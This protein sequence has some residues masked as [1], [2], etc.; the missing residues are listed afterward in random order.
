VTLSGSTDSGT[1]VEL[2]DDQNSRGAAT[3]SGGTWSKTLTL[4]DGAHHFTARA[5]D[6]A[7]NQSAVSD[8]RTFVV[9]TGAPDAPALSGPSGPINTAAPQFTFSTSEQGASFECALDSADFAACT[10]PLALSGI[11]EGAH[12]FK[13]RAIDAAHNTGPVASTDFTVDLTPPAEPTVVSG[14]SGPTTDASPAFD[15]NE[16]EQDVTVE[17]RLDGPSGAQ[18]T[19]VKDCASPKRFNALAPGDYTFLVRATDS[20]GNSKTTSRSFTV[21]VPQQATPTPT[22]TPSPTPSPSP[23]PT[24]VPRHSVVVGPASGKVLIKVRGTGKF[25]PLDVTKGIPLGSEVDARKGHVTL[26]AIPK[27]GK[28]AENAEFWNG[29]FVVTQKNGVTDVK[30]SQALTGCPKN[31][32]SAHAAVEKKKKKKPKTRRLWGNGKGSFRTT[33]RYSAATIR[34]TKWLVTDTCTSTVTK[35][36]RGVVAVKDF[37]KKKTV[38]VKAPKRYTAKAKKKKRKRR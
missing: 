22:P 16:G 12:T 37:A 29:I 4:T 21:T 18:G 35:V 27:P 28:P 23:S 30:L 13:V 17:C 34:G 5:T 10:S 2:F 38:L 26:T 11:S 8:A 31:A 24:P 6:A 36:A 19:F 15:F 7:G 9:D 3:V 20:A 1:T 14:P 25:V 33:G 32:R